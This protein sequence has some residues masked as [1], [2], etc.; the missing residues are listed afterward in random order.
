M[1]G[2]KIAAER[3]KMKI[4]SKDFRVRPGAKVKPHKDDVAFDASGAWKNFLLNYRQSIPPIE[5]TE[6]IAENVWLIHLESELL[7]I[8]KLIGTLQNFSIPIRVLFLEGAQDLIKY[9]PAAEDKP[10]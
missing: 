9:P 10:S 2:S 3:I 5:K 4:N 6:P 1:S 8:S 7:V